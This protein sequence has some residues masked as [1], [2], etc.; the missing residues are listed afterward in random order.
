MKAVFALRSSRLELVFL[1]MALVLPCTLLAATL[2]PKSLEQLI[3]G[4][5]L[6]VRGHVQAVRPGPSGKD[7]PSTTVVIAVKEQ[8]KGAKL[9]TF[10]MIQPQGTEGGIA[11]A[12]PGLPTFRVGEDVILFVAREGHGRYHVLGGKQGKFSVR[13]DVAT[14]KQVVEDLTGARLD[15]DQFISHLAPPSRPVRQ[16]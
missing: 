15:L 12:V 1:A 5:D 6:I 16:R 4:A 14:G 8:W 13:S 9:S 2:A 11:Q 3:D 10:K 7:G